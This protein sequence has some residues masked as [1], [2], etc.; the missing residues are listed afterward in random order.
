[1]V[2]RSSDHALEAPLGGEAV[3]VGSDGLA[4]VVGQPLPV[5][6]GEGVRAH[7]ALAHPQDAQLFGDGPAQV[8][9]RAQGQLHAA[10]PD[11]HDEGA[12]SL[13]VDAVEGCEVDQPSLGL[14]GDGPGPD[15]DLTPHPPKEVLAVRRFA[16]GGGRDRED[17]VGALGFGQMLVLAE[18]LEA[19][20]HG[21][22]GEP[23]PGHRPRSQADHG[24]LGGHDTEATR[25]V[26]LHHHQVEGVA[27]QVDG[28]DPHGRAGR[29]EE[30]VLAP[31]GR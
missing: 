30:P 22:G 12:L 29:R 6:P 16:D 10:A 2:P 8:A 11:V 17:L 27:A 19:S 24:L 13:E 7:E 5:P 14:S 25:G 18:D 3:H 28:R 15:P 9:A 1:M 4:D 31:A 26:H 21:A 20:E 23:S